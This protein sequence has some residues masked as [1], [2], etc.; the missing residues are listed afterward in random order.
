MGHIESH[1]KEALSRTVQEAGA[2]NMF[3]GADN[4]QMGN[5]NRTDA[6]NDNDFVNAESENQ[7]DIGFVIAVHQELVGLS[8]LM[9]IPK[10]TQGNGFKYYSTHWKKRKVVIVESGIGCDRAGEATESLIQVF[11]PKR[12][13][14]AGFAGAL[15]TELKK[16]QIV[17][18]NRLVYQISGEEL[19]LWGRRLAGPEGSVDSQQKASETNDSVIDRFV[20]GT[21][22]TA[23]HVVSDPKEKQNFR[24]RFSASLVD[25]E[26]WAVAHICLKYGIPFLPVRVIFDTAE[27]PISREVKNITE[28]TQ[29][30]A[31]MMGALF[32]AISK[33]PSSVLEL[34]K[35]KENS[36]VAS[37]T[38][39]KAIETILS[40]S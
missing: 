36:L 21:L 6:D 1:M 7:I 13:I 19:D 23:D 22:L 14:S 31:R 18:P 24:K 25:M 4:D 37:D 29:N 15:N 38:L 9:G 30:V 32:G 39:A 8:D 40:L 16:N 2:D 3:F 20:T 33:R 28:N 34:Y 10:V 17:I 35:L 26:T 27:E 5:N 11:Q 12:I